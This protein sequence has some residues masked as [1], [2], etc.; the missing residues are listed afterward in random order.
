MMNFNEARQNASYRIQEA[1]VAQATGDAQESLRLFELAFDAEKQAA[2]LLLTR[3]EEEPTRSVAFRSAASL[4]MNCKKY[5]DAK[6]M[7][8]FGLAGNPPED[9]AQELID[10]YEQEK[11]SVVGVME[12]P[13]NEVSKYGIVGAAIGTVLSQMVAAYL[14]DLFNPKTRSVFWMKTKSFM[15]FYR[16]KFKGL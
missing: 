10:I 11:A 1:I 3:F 9:I 8:H 12:V 5:E 13:Q 16:Y 7:I 4:A 2:L 15:P 6:K 14:F